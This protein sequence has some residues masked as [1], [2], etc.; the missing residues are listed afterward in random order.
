MGRKKKTEE[1]KK[2]W[3]AA[4]NKKR[5]EANK[6]KLAAIGKVYREANK[7][8]IKACRDVRDKEKLKAQREANEEKFRAN[9]DTK[10]LPYYIVYALPNFN[11][12]DE[13]YCGQ[14]NQPIHRMNGHKCKGND[15][16]EWFILDICSTR[17]EALVI[18]AQYHDQG[19]KGRDGDS[20]KN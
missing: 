17:E 12:T 6:E 7:E 8:K 9:R 20:K 14:T 11:S 5:Y 3:R 13:V 15:T 2:E 1:Q 19:Y 16:S 4:Y 10:I 18:E